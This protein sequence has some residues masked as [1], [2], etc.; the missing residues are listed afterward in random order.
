MS[1]VVPVVTKLA[2]IPVAAYSQAIKA[3]GFIYISGQ[4]P[5]TTDNKLVEG[6]KEDIKVQTHQVLKNLRGVVEG[7]GSSWEKLVK[8]NIFITDMS[9]FPLV[10]EVYA[11]YFTT[12]KPARSC[13][14]V[15]EL[16][17]GADIEIEAVA[18]Q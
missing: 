5:L 4:V 10:N 16:P 15:R 6:G 18:L 17:L 12:H 7:A 11:E 8:L 2:P 13:V 3:G 9:K 14:A 1:G